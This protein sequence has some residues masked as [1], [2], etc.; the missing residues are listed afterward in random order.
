LE[1]YGN[2][3]WAFEITELT[4]EI[5]KEEKV[6]ED[7]IL[8]ADGSGWNA[9]A[10]HHIDPHQ[11]RKNKWIASADGKGIYRVYGFKY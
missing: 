6:R 10:M 7:P 11:I 5:Y 4:A 2:Q 3:I 1:I 9:E 8:K